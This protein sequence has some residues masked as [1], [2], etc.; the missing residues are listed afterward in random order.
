MT[1]S[2]LVLPAPKQAVFIHTR[3]CPPEW[4][5]GLEAIVPKSDTVPWL[6]IHWFAGRDYAAVQRW[7]IWEMIPDLSLIP[8]EYLAD[9]K[10]PNPAT[11]GRWVP[12]DSIPAEFGSRR[13]ESASMHS[14]PQWELFRLTGC[15]PKLFWIIQ[16]TK[17]GHVWRLDHVTKHF[18]IT[19]EGQ[20]VPNPG[21]LP[22]AEWSPLVAH[23]IAEFDRLRRWEGK[24][25]QPWTD[26]ALNTTDAG[27][28]VQKET[29]DLEQ[30]YQER[31][32]KWLDNQ[33]ED[34]MQDVADADLPSWSDLPKGD[35]HFN[36]DAEALHNLIV[37][38]GSSCPVDQLT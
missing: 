37:R 11:H 24:M 20:D 8:P 1:A 3:E 34:A 7:A 2:V 16:G 33:I 13:W 12:D 4:Q 19:I 27:L 35:T 38:E 30:Q 9:I 5:A 6:K 31:M 14:R 15:Y 23:Q 32:L 25:R 21:D 26:R 36:K 18:A 28:L 22:Y 17:G 10:G 29:W